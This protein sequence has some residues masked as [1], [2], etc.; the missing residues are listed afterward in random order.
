[1]DVSTLLEMAASGAGDRIAI[2]PRDAGVT[3]GTL[4][5]RARRLAGW[6]RSRDAQHVGYVGLNS[7]LIPVLLFGSALAGAP[8]APVNYR[9]DDDTLRSV[10]SRLAPGLV[11][12]DPEVAERIGRIDGIDLVTTTDLAAELDDR[13]TD[14]VHRKGSH[15]D[16]A[17]LLFTSGT[18]GD[19]KVAVLRH[20]HLATY[21]IE[22]V[23][24]LGAEED[25]CSLISVPAYH[26]AGVSAVL[27][28]VYAG[29]RI[30]FLPSFSPEGWVDACEREAVTHAMVVPTMLGRV[31]NIVSEGDRELPHLRHVSYGGGAMP[32]PVVE[33][34]L[35]VWP[36]V[37]FTNAYGLTETSSTIALLGPEEHREAL[38]G[39]THKVRR[40]LGSVGR[41]LPTVEV[42]VRDP[43]GN[44][45]AAGE[46]GE[47]WVRGG[48]IAGEYLGQSALTDDGW[49]RTRDA[50]W[51]D[52][53]GYLFVEGR[54]D[55]VIVRGA[56]NLSPGE[57]E[58]ALRTHDAVGDA[59][60]VGVPDEDW[61]ERVVAVVV[62]NDGKRPD[63]DELREWV[64]S[65]LR[66]SKTPDEI[67]FVD[68]LPYTDTGKLLR[69]TV[70]SDVLGVK[71]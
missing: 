51:C 71:R 46:R 61:G 54:L 14:L 30:A 37:G 63:E 18:T 62:C 4:L 17:V 39:T 23:E 21:V 38:R 60:V 49:F 6:L 70:K 28:A 1:M 41:P 68:E 48:Q 8:Y 43:A 2:G 10:V 40:R 53:D 57:I 64:R 20:R 5:N 26:I 69:R 7:D 58:S 47:V 50:G 42:Q 12:A 59:A 44:V 3:Y 65:R 25:E 9:L 24:F 35:R 56:E 19:P 32:V 66:S 55:D 15:D 27:S 22:T 36:H 33:R 52:E 13:S 67:H 11:V 45:L 34:A 29:R 16:P 31:L